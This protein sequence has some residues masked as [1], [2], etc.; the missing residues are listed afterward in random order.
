MSE[1]A[2]DVPPDF[3]ATDGRNS[4]NLEVSTGFGATKVSQLLAPIGTPA[5]KTE[6]QA[7]IRPQTIKY[8]FS[9]RNFILPKNQGIQLCQSHISFPQVSPKELRVSLIWW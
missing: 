2:N 5:V 6:V 7:D 9:L 1:A 4:A 3:V 8:I